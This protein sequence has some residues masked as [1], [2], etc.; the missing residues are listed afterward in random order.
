MKEKKKTL[1]LGMKLNKPK[2]TEKEKPCQKTL[3]SNGAERLLGNEEA[4]MA[5]SRNI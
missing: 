1:E 4:V 5:S 2:K 3:G